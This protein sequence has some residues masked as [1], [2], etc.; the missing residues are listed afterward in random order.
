MKKMAII[1]LTTLALLGSEF[2][3]RRLK[4]WQNIRW[5]PRLVATFTAIFLSI[6]MLMFIFDSGFRGDDRFLGRANQWSIRQR[7]RYRS[8]HC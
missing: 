7:W 5:I 8:E 2:A 6:P 3:G 4:S 1:T